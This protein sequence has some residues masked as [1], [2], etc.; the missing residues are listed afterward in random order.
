MKLKFLS[1]SFFLC[2]GLFS[3]LPKAQQPPGGGFANEKEF[4]ISIG[5]DTYIAA[6]EPIPAAQELTARSAGDVAAASE[7]LAQVAIATGSIVKIT[8]ALKGKPLTTFTA[9]ISIAPILITEIKPL[10][11]AATNL[12]NIG[13]LYQASQGLTP[14]ERA[15]VATHFAL[16]FNLPHSQAEKISELV[17]ESAVVN[18]QLY[19]EIAELKKQ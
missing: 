15:A 7:Y 3:C 14:D 17:V 12:K 1:F 8:D 9:W 2:L 16:K 6:N 18:M 5:A 11:I 4:S 13:L 19:S 10:I